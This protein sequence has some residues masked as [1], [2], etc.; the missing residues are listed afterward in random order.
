MNNPVF[1]KLSETETKTCLENPLCNPV[2]VSFTQRAKLCGQCSYFSKHQNCCK[3]EKLEDKL[4]EFRNIN[5]KTFYSVNSKKPLEV[6]IDCFSIV[7]RG[8]QGANK[9]VLNG[10]GIMFLHP[11]C[12]ARYD[13]VVIRSTVTNIDDNEDDKIPLF[14]I[15]PDKPPTGKKP[16]GVMDEIVRATKLFNTYAMPFVYTIIAIVIFFFISVPI[17]V[18]CVK[19]YAAK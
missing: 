1:T 2:Q 17:L 12:E 13:N 4:P 6:T 14:V 8:A 16:V 18:F 19:N 15:K 5:N 11:G 10:S 7:S 3:Y 9:K